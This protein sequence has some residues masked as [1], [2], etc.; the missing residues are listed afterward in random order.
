MAAMDEYEI[1]QLKKAYLELNKKIARIE[2]FALGPSPDDWREIKFQKEALEKR[3]KYLESVIEILK[4]NLRSSSKTFKNKQ[5]NQ[6]YLTE[7]T[8][9][10]NTAE[11]ALQ[12]IRKEIIE[13]ENEYNLLNIPRE[14]MLEVQNKLK[15]ERAIIIKAMLKQKKLK[16]KV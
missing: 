16:M 3:A 4:K 8:N 11:S 7:M 5:K 2:K 1:K 10:L 6:P 12:K 15:E 13:K 9:Q 14:E